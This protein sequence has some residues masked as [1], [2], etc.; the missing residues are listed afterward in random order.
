MGDAK[1][2]GSPG[3]CPVSPS[4]TFHLV[5]VKKTEEQ[6]EGLLPWLSGGHLG[7]RVSEDLRGE[8]VTGIKRCRRS[9]GHQSQDLHK[10]PGS[11]WS[12]PGQ[13]GSS[14]GKSPGKLL[15]GCLGRSLAPRL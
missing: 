1:F 15:V 4:P 5:L 12:E 11:L 2:G 7:I 13:N 10:G 3:R 8:E 6:M 9:Q 14:G